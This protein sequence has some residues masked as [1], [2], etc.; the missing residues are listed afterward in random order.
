MTCS[1]AV[2]VRKEPGGNYKK[3]F[4]P[5]VLAALTSRCW[6]VNMAGSETKTR[7]DSLFMEADR[8][9]ELTVRVWFLAPLSPTSLSVAFS[10]VKKRPRCLYNTKTSFATPAW[11][12]QEIMSQTGEAESQ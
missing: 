4:S 12:K 5:R 9:W 3:G 7:L 6:R 8:T 2:G 10:V 11:R 1:T